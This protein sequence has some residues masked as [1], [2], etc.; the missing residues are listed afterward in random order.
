MDLIEFKVYDH[1]TFSDDQIA[2]TVDLKIFNCVGPNNGMTADHHLFYQK[3]DRGTIKIR[4]QYIPHAAP[5]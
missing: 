3:K 4:T 1:N 5:A 2:H